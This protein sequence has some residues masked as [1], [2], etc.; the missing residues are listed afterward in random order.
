MA[1]YPDIEESS[2]PPRTVNGESSTADTQNDLREP[3][4]NPGLRGPNDQEDLQGEPLDSFETSCKVND[5]DA[6]NEDDSNVEDD[7]EVSNAQTEVEDESS[8][9]AE[10]TENSTQKTCKPVETDVGPAPVYN[11][12]LLGQTQAGKSTFLEGIKRYVDPR[13]V[14]NDAAIGDGVSS[15]TN[16][17]HELRLDTEF[18]EYYVLDTTTKQE[19]NIEELRSIRKYTQGTL[20]MRLDRTDDRKVR[21]KRSSLRPRSTIRIFDTPGLDDTNGHDVRNVAKILT[22]LS[23]AKV[24][25]VHL[26]LIILSRHTPM[27]PGLQ[28]ALQTYHNIFSAMNGLMAVVYTKV[29]DYDQVRADKRLASFLDKSSIILEKIMQRNIPYHLIDCDLEETRPFHIYFRQQAIRKIILLA[30]FN[31]PVSLNRLQ[32]CKTPKMI[33]IDKLVHERFRERLSTIASRHSQTR[34]AVAMYQNNIA[35]HNLKILEAQYKI[36]ELEESLANQDTQDPELIQEFAYDRNWHIGDLVP[37]DPWGLRRGVVLECAEIEHS[38]D[39]LQAEASKVDVED[40]KGGVDYSHWSVKVTPRRLQ[41]SYYRSKLFVKRCNKFRR[42]IVTTK[43]QLADWKNRLQKLRLELEGL[44]GA[45]ASE[46][47]VTIKLIQEQGH[48]LDMMARATRK[49]LH[50]NLFKAM[51]M[52]GVFE[53]S[54][55]DCARNVELFYQ[56]YVPMEGEEVALAPY[57]P[58]QPEP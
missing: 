24:T 13:C 21:A 39:V 53:G 12:I 58:Q 10:R 36:R 57:T 15:H 56:S 45:C 47:A 19:V 35:E 26:V 37:W 17:V 4:V 6:D 42:E 27:T 20:A 43:S 3:L 5:A 32:L 22:A 38:I 40:V 9:E 33:D 1:Q 48:Y 29:K 46:D 7:E 41:T 44:Q 34:E 23:E 11:I 28:N 14:I 30:A 55:M 51:A 16:E 2:S 25:E 18:P 49:T 31:I 50:L 52:G 8:T 54:S